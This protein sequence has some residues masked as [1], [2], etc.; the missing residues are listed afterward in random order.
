MSLGGGCSHS[1]HHN[2][3]AL[4]CHEVNILALHNLTLMLASL[5][6]SNDGASYLWAEPLKS[7]A[8]IDSPSL[9][10]FL[11]AAWGQEWTLGVFF[12]PTLVLSQS[13]SLNLEF[14]TRPA[15]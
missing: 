4:S 13:L 14:T 2:R 8:E 5:Q 11:L 12:A 7:Q 10:V 3:C 9:Y 6:L 15:G 1:G